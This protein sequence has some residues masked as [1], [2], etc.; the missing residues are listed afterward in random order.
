M[1]KVERVYSTLAVDNV[2]FQAKVKFTDEIL[3]NVKQSENKRERERECYG[4]Y[5]WI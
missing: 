4:P 2:G 1:C 5:L 3:Q